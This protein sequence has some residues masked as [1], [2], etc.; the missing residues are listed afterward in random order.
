MRNIGCDLWGST[1]PMPLW[2][3]PGGVRAVVFALPGPL[4]PL[5]RAAPGVGGS[6]ALRSPASRGWLAFR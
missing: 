5:R 2:K 4:R 6:T 3:I 1:A